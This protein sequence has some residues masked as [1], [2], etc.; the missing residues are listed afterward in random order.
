MNRFIQ[1]VMIAFVGVFAVCV[2]AIIVYA[3]YWQA[4]EKRCEMFGN[5]WDAHDRVCAKPVFL[6]D[7]THRPI[8]SPKRKLGDIQPIMIPPGG[9]PHP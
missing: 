4:P 3:I 7:I 8:G 2:V 6:P 9:S 1:R 5:W